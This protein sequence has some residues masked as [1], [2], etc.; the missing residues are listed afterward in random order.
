M[1]EKDK[2]IRVDNKE[3]KPSK[4]GRYAEKLNLKIDFKKAVSKAL[5]TK[6]IIDKKV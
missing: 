6:I 1:K 3:Q 2:K 4:K 5:N